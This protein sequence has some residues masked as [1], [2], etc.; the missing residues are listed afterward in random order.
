MEEAPEQLEKAI[1][2]AARVKAEANLEVEHARQETLKAEI[3]LLRA[4]TKVLVARVV[5]TLSRGLELQRH[6]HSQLKATTLLL[7][8]ADSELED[9][10]GELKVLKL[11]LKAL[12]CKLKV[13]DRGL[14]L[15]LAHD[16]AL[17]R[18][19]QLDLELKAMP[20]RSEPLDSEPEDEEDELEVLDRKVKL[21][22]ELKREL[23]EYEASKRVRKIE[24]EF[25]RTVLAK[26]SD[27]RS[28]NAEKGGIYSSDLPDGKTAP[29]HLLKTASA[30][31]ISLP[32]IPY[33]RFAWRP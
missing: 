23:A 33:F 21:E 2:E 28:N 27:S 5:R 17:L 22:L 13:L 29:N 31:H 11:K 3:E 14:K 15:S 24:L 18:G 4:D 9:E 30:M 26:A 7:E 6:V 10:E 19:L 32:S 25:E 16:Q 8:S 12:Y 20:F 1:P